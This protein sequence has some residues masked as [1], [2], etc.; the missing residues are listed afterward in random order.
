M[1]KENAIG[2]YFLQVKPLPHVIGFLHLTPIEYCCTHAN[3][4]IRNLIFPHPL[5]ATF[6]C[7]FKSD[8]YPICGLQLVIS[9]I[10]VH[11]GK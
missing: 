8:A 3:T 5:R 4:E 2:I 7:G 1:K 9:N 6:K 10:Y 11:A